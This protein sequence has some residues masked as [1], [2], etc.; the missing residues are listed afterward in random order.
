MLLKTNFP[1]SKLLTK[2]NISI[3]EIVKIILIYWYSVNF[4]LN[5]IVARDIH[6][7]LFIL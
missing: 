7:K 2:P 5:E 4:Y 1:N 3:H 6:F